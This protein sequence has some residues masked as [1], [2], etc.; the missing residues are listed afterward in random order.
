M[1]SIAD[2]GD[3]VK[4]LARDND[5]ALLQVKDGTGEGL[6]TIYIPFE[7]VLINISDMHMQCCESGFVLEDNAEVI[8]FDY[9]REGRM[10]QQSDK[11]ISTV[12]QEGQLRIDDRKS[13][14]GHVFFP[15]RHYHG[16]SICMDVVCAERGID[17]VMPGFPVH[18]R[19]LRKKFCADSI[20][21]V[22]KN[23]SIIEGIMAD[24]QDS[25]TNISADYYKLKILEL[26]LYLE[27]VEIKNDH[28]KKTYFFQNAGDKLREI[29]TQITENPALHFTIKE[30]SEEFDIPQTE[31]K[32]SFKE[33]YG[34]SIYSYLKRY[35]INLAASML[36]K[37][38]DKNVS[39]IAHAVGYESTGKF[40]AAFKQVLA[41][42]P[43][44]YRKHRS[45]KADSLMNL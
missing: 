29:H 35:R 17:S 14:T 2:L 27:T 5:H 28:K 4:V 6:M 41:T 30:L 38:Q 13:H 16:V 44:D 7:G 25:P 12:L 37:D 8:C 24:I 33:M 9:C 21:Y 15:L 10:E 3:N 32:K 45:D 23:D 18:L 19:Q 36:I 22:L 26:L 39:E 43:L 1:R 40:S 11:G 20:P 42:T 34:D 31:L